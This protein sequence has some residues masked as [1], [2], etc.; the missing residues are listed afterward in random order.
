MGNKCN[1]KLTKEIVE[2]A[3]MNSQSLGATLRY[4][5]FDSKIG[6]RYPW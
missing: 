6:S 4:L 3:V 1:K 5:G 2:E